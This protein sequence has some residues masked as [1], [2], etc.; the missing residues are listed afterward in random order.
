[1]K[2]IDIYIPF[3]YKVGIIGRIYEVNPFPSGALL[4]SFS[5][6]S[7]FSC[8]HE[9]YNCKTYSTSVSN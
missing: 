1:M 6:D 7:Y 3:N 8:D 5:G 4:L 2:R 9:C